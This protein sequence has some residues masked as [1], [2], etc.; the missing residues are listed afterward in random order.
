MPIVPM[1]ELLTCAREGAYGVGYFEAWDIDS[2]EAVIA[3]AEAEKAPVIVGFGGA[4]A[5][6]AWLD[7]GGVEALAGIGH[8]LASRTR[9]PSALLFNE[10]HSL[11]QARR[12]V[13]TGFNAV[14]LDTSAWPWE[15]AVTEVADL[16]AYAHERGASVEA[17]LGRLPDAV[18]GGVDD[19][20]ASLTDPQQAADFAQRTGIDC[21]AV[22]VGNVHLLRDRLA[23]VDMGHLEAVAARVPLPLVMHGGTSFPPDEVPRAIAAGVA[24][25]NVGTVLKSEFLAGVRDTVAAWPEQVNVHDILGSHK[26]TDL[27]AAGKARMQLRV[28]ELIR[29]Y[30]SHGRA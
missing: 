6:G 8:A 7:A 2:L 3:A 27:L 22:S 17:E 5:A 29:L 13:D 30:G 24:K 16:V 21:L 20:H 11:D 9:M 1:T 12:A 19:S 23:P 4:M 10:A 18:E 26:A 15:D 25:F 14:M 28:Q